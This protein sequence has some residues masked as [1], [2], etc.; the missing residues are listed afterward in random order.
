MGK[1]YNRL[2]AW[3]GEKTM[4]FNVTDALISPLGLMMLTGAGFGDASEKNIKHI[5][6]TM[7]ALTDSTGAAKISYDDIKKEIGTTENIAICD[8]KNVKAYATILDGT[9][10]IVDWADIVEVTEEVEDTVKKA[11]FTVK[12]SPAEGSTAVVQKEKNV[13]LDFYV[14]MKSGLTQ[15]TIEPGDFGGT[16]YVEADTLYRDQNGKDMAATITFP[17][18]KIQ[19]GFTIAMAANGDPSTFD[20]VMDCMPGYT[21]FD[22]TKKVVCD[23]TIIGGAAKSAD[24]NVKHK[25]EHAKESINK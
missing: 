25:D 11:V 12:K 7:H 17:C 19:S 22:T 2:V 4:T 5:H 15:I 3:E 16:F 9:G 13:K 8:D 23:I 1:G 10:A 21:F 18:A 14:I 6:V 20:F 24:T